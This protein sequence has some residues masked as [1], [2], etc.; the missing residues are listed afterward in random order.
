M[1]PQMSDKCGLFSFCLVSEILQVGPKRAMSR[2]TVL[3]EAVGGP[4]LGGFGVEQVMQMSGPS[5]P[6]DSNPWVL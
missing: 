4:C 5:L 6:S 1:G 2:T 3:V